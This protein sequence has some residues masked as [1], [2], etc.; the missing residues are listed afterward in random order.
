MVSRF[1]KREQRLLLDF[2]AQFD[3]PVREVHEVFP[4]VVMRKADVKL[5]ERTPLGPA[6]LADEVHARFAWRT[7]ALARIAQD[8]RTH[9]VLPC[10]GPTAIARDDMV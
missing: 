8:A 3:V 10:R 7:I 2:F 6:R 9:N 5:N 1:P 4:T